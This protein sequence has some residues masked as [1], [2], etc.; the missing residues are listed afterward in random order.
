[1]ICDEPGGKATARPLSPPPDG[2]TADPAHLGRQ[3]R[4]Q[5]IGNRTM[6]AT[7]EIYRQWGIETRTWDWGDEN[8][9]PWSINW[10]LELVNAA[11][12]DRMSEV[13]R[14]TL[15]CQL[16]GGAPPLRQTG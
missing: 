11:A 15:Y 7:Q 14:Q 8:P 4:T 13:D 3:C 12:F 6:M 1:M 10:A 5:R 9:Q 2:S 16:R